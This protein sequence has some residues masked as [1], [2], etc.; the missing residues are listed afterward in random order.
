MADGIEIV[1]DDLDHLFVAPPVDPYA[2]GFSTRSGV[3]RCIDRLRSMR[4]T[5]PIPIR[6]VVP[7]DQVDPVT[8]DRV[9]RALARWCDDQITTNRFRR[10]AAQ[11]DGWTSLKFGIP[12]TLVGFT[13][14][15]TSSDAAVGGQQVDDVL[16]E[17]L[18]WVLS[19]VG[20]WFP[21][22]ALVFGPM[23]VG[24]ETRAWM[25]LRD[26]PLTLAPRTAGATPR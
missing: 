26:A 8:T 6:L 19:W 5:D 3:D 22:D 7:A 9:R 14:V 15:A 13:L 20:L 18:G 16:L 23:L 10:R 2:D 25:R 21:V 24:R 12:A 17:H 11:L 1:L 4:G